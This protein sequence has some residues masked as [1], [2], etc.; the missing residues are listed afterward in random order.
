VESFVAGIKDSSLPEPAGKH[1]AAKT[2]ERERERERRK[3][4]NVTLE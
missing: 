2:R 4:K 1:Y 3:K